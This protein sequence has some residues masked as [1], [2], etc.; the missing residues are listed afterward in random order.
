MEGES[1]KREMTEHLEEMEERVHYRLDLSF[2]ISKVGA[3]TVIP[4]TFL[5]CQFCSESYKEWNKLDRQ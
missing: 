3:H 1:Q 2:L 5:D 4:Q